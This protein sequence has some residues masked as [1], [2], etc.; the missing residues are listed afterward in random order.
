MQDQVFQEIARSRENQ[1]TAL[2]LITHDISLV[3][4]N[5]ERIAVMYAGQIVEMASAAEIFS[6]PLHPYTIGLQNAFADLER[7]HRTL[8]SIPGAMPD[9]L[10]PPTGC[11]FAERCP[12]ARAQCGTP[13]PL[14]E[15]APGHWA[16]CHFTHEAELFRVAARDEATWERT[17]ASAREPA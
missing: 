1:S 4:E 8:I 10:S 6:A 3:A 15:K 9:L 14:Q 17:L 16:A 7:E 2:I 13:P 5:C 12:F 11:R